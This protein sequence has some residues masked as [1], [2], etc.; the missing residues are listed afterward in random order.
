M[1][2]YLF[3]IYIDDLLVGLEKLGYGC[4]I[5]KL[6][7]GVLAYADDIILLAPSLSALRVILDFCTYYA[8]MHNITVTSMKSYCIRF[9]LHDISVE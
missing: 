2:Y 5:G 1:I 6:F 3:Y 8:I 7:Y 4:F 9:S